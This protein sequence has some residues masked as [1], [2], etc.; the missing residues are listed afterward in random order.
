MILIMA[1]LVATGMCTLWAIVTARWT[2]ALCGMGLLLGLIV[3]LHGGKQLQHDG[4]QVKG[5]PY[6][7]DA[8]DTLTV[9]PE[10][11]YNGYAVYR[12]GDSLVVKDFTAGNVPA[13]IHE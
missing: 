1:F 7:L 6:R 5:E 8:G 2:I 10:D 12:S 3:G 4:P 11:R 13:R 9:V